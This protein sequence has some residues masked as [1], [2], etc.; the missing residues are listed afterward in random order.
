[1]LVKDLAVV[2]RGEK[3]VYNIVTA[4]G[5][6]AVLV[7]VLQQPD[8]NAVA[9]AGAV[10]K[11]ILDMRRTLPP[12]TDLSIFY[13]QS[14]LVKDSIGSVTGASPWGWGFRSLCCCYF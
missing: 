7:N 12:D 14:V 1:M 10:N 3:P 9:I 11:E 2:V 4:N 5:R 13:D 6:P 8:G